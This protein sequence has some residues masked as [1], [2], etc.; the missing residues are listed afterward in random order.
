MP[1]LPIE[2]VSIITHDLN[3]PTS[4]LINKQYLKDKEKD[5]IDGLQIKLWHFIVENV[6]YDYFL[7]HIGDQFK[8]SRE[9]EEH[10]W[11]EILKLSQED[12]FFH[13]QFMDKIVNNKVRFMDEVYDDINSVRGLMFLNNKLVITE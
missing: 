5:F 11:K 8:T 2:V 13:I 7:D 10:Q 9:F 6:S 1:R 3:L 12:L 4:R